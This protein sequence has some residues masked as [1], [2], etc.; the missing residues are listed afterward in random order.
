MTA[1]SPVWHELEEK[2]S[3]LRILLRTV[4]SCWLA[5][6]VSHDWLLRQNSLA[7]IQGKITIIKSRDLKALTS[8]KLQCE[9][10]ERIGWCP[11]TSLKRAVLVDKRSVMSCTCSVWFWLCTPPTHKGLFGLRLLYMTLCEVN[12]TIV[13][14][15]KGYLSQLLVP[16]TWNWGE[17]LVVIFV[18]EG[19]GIDKDYV[20]QPI[21]KTLPPRTLQKGARCRSSVQKQLQLPCDSVLA[22]I[23]Q[24]GWRT[25]QIGKHGR[26]KS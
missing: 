6:L 23:K 11:T 5:L 15:H 16:P 2:E 7:M 14:S 1:Q 9:A 4:N 18:L 12:C 19:G 8:L 3:L 13:I 10:Y 20:Q 24:T 17:R 22:L 26:H 25:Q 21:R